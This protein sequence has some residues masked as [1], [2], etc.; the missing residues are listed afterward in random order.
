MLFAVQGLMPAATVPETRHVSIQRAVAQGRVDL[1]VDV[2][3]D[4]EQRYGRLRPVPEELT[5]LDPLTRR[6]AVLDHL[7]DQTDAASHYMRVR[8]EDLPPCVWEWFSRAEAV[9][10]VYT[11]PQTRREVRHV[12]VAVWADQS[13]AS[14][15]ARHVRVSAVATS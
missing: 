10:F 14:L 5:A 6:R 7:L 1:D 3:E 4:V 11:D 2:P 12:V 8:A 9:V 15:R 13:R